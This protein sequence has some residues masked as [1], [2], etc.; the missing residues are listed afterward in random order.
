[1]LA[2]VFEKIAVNIAPALTAMAETLIKNVER[3][4]KS[5]AA[6]GASWATVGVIAAETGGFIIDR[7]SEVAEKLLLAAAAT[8]TLEAAWRSLQFAMGKG[9]AEDVLGAATAAEALKREA[10][11]RVAERVSGASSK[12][13]M[14]RIQQI[15]RDAQSLANSG[16]LGG[17]VGA[18]GAGTKTLLERGSSAAVLRRRRQRAAQPQ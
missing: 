12:E 15:Q 16:K 2:G 1:V 4:G 10:L 13:F 14:L 5:I 6:F 9:K 7:M 3:M 17:G 11:A 8:K 18:G